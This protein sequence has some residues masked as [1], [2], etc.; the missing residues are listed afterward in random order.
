V[1]RIGGQVAIGT[2]FCN[3]GESALAVPVVMVAPSGPLLGL[4]GA[5]VAE[6]AA[7][8]ELVQRPL[9]SARPPPDPSRCTWH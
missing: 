1:I 7:Q 4:S 8:P 2:V 6:V 5:N 3:G 9:E